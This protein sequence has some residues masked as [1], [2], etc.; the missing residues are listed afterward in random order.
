MCPNYD[1]LF[2]KEDLNRLYWDEGLS[3]AQIGSKYGVSFM[4]VSKN[5]KRLGVPVRSFSVL[6]SH[7]KY[8]YDHNFFKSVTHESS[9][10]LGCLFADGCICDNGGSIYLDLS[11]VDYD[12]LEL[13]RDLMKSNHKIVIGRKSSGSYSSRACYKFRICV[14]E[15]INDLY[16]LGMTRTKS[17]TVQFPDIPIEYVPDFIR[18]YHDGNGSFFVDNRHRLVSSVSSTK[19]F[20]DAYCYNLKLLGM[21][22]DSV[23][24]MHSNKSSKM[25]NKVFTGSK[26]IDFA[27]LVYYD[28]GVNKMNRKYEIAKQ[29][30]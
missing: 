17:Q 20:L 26:A 12:W 7:P 16:V 6:C 13:V 15:L 28:V 14:R 10:V 3:Q 30:M 22:F 9:Y 29:F 8:S 2:T 24:F 4:T 25:W 19:M 23:P 1:S 18:G 27:K 11:S 21:K 5:M